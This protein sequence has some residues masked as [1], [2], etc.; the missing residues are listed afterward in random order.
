MVLLPVEVVTF[1]RRCRG[2]VARHGAVEAL[3]AL[4]DCVVAMAVV[5][6][7]GRRNCQGGRGP[8]C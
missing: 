6:S 5:S 4:T 8:P 7:L 3:A 2:G 1:R